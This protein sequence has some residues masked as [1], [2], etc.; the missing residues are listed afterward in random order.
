MEKLVTQD[1][2]LGIIAGGQLGKML[3]LAANKWDIKTSVLDS[4]RTCPA[5]YVCSRFMQGDYTQFDTIVKFGR[6]VD[7]ITL[8]IENVN[9]EALK[10]L[11]SEGKEIYPDP[12]ILEIIQDKGIQNE[13]L[14]KHHFPTSKFKLFDSTAALKKAVNTNEIS[15]PF[16]QKFRQTGYDGNGVKIVRSLKDL[17]KLP[18]SL[19]VIEDLV[20][21]KKEISVVIARNSAGTIKSYAPVEMSFNSE[22]N[23][24]EQIICPAILSEKLKI[25]AESLALSIVTKLD[26]IGIMAVEM[27]LDQDDELWI[28]EIAPRTHNSGHHTIESSITSQYEQQLRAILNLPLG[29]TEMMLSAVMINILGEPGYLGTVKYEGLTESMAIE[30][31]KIHIYGKKETRPY[32]KMGH[33]TV[34]DA[35]INKALN[36]AKKID[37]FIKVISND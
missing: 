14:Q 30:G 22:A 25:E 15:F 36:K 2:R 18:S 32:R 37:E 33:V 7:I 34:L 27:F 16:V 4:S 12:D 21:V 3:V 20:P 19:F 11:K 8:E 6:S 26:Y 28:N 24:V 23:L 17:N 29:S 35:S 1:F 13:F 10:L 5:S 9:L 31:V